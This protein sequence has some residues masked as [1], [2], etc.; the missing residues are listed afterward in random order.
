MEE[1]NKNKAEVHVMNIEAV[2]A[3]T[4]PN[5]VVHGICVN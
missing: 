5:H 1:C 4:T 3:L 2:Y